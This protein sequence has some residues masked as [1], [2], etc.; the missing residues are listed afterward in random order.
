VG[1]NGQSAPFPSAGDGVAALVAELLALGA[2]D[3]EVELGHVPL[4][5][6]PRS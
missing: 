4:T 1:G 6:H 5:V 3:V 2:G